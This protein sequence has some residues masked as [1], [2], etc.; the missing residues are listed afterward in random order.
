MAK[1]GGGAVFTHSNFITCI[2]KVQKALE[3]ER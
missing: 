3:D 1:I 2:G